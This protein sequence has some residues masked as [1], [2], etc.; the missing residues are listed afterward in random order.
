M[1]ILWI[2]LGIIVLLFLLSLLSV[3]LV[4]EYREDVT[5][6]LSILFFKFRLFPKDKKKSKHL[7]ASK[8][9]KKRK[10]K[11][12]SPK[13]KKGD[14]S[15]HSEEKSLPERLSDICQLLSELL[16]KTLGH[17]K[18]RAAR[19]RISVASKDAASTAIL[20]GAVHQ[21]VAF[22]LEILDRFSTLKMGRRDEIEVFPNF[23]EE[24]TTAD[25]RL[26]FFLRVWQILDILLKSL[27]TYIKTKS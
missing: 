12:K 22:L 6:T 3:R 17:L 15:T 27:C 2:L 10:R 18:I 5:L 23:L 7:F 11:E 9:T 4:L 13:E 19:I 16:K 14:T 20:F 21:G 24:K 25:L 1:T 8:K 26:I